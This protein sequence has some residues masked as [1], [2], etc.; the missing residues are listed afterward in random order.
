MRKFPLPDRFPS[1]P[2][3]N[4]ASFA[5]DTMLEDGFDAETAARTTRR[6]QGMNFDDDAGDDESKWKTQWATTI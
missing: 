6:Q 5:D 2:P 3:R 4:E 1:Q